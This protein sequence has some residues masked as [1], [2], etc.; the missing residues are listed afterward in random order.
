MTS[1]LTQSELETYLRGAANTLRGL[2][3]AG[4]YKQIIFPLLFYKRL[5]D[6]WY[7][8]YAWAMADE[9]FAIPPGALT[10]RSAAC[11]HSRDWKAGWSSWLKSIRMQ[12]IS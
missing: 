11:T 12:A 9:R 2:I 6:A 3:D 4:S 7:E 5:S 1:R 10:S 8:D